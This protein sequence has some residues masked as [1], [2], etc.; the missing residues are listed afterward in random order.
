LITK[1]LH[2]EGDGDGEVAI[3]VVIIVEAPGLDR[4]RLTLVRELV[5]HVGDGK[6]AF[7]L[8]ECEGIGR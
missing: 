1:C 5:A 8:R 7:A 6:E 2:G 3:V 4:E